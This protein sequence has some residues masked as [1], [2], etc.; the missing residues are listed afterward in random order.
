MVRHYVVVDN[1]GNKV[2]GIVAGIVGNNMR[3]VV[4]V[5]NIANLRGE[6]KGLSY[7]QILVVNL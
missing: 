6:G 3:G 1:D 2:G 5:S 4:V 7:S